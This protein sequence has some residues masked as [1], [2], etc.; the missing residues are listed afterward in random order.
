[1][2]TIQKFNYI[3]LEQTD[4]KL[5]HFLEALSDKQRKEI[6]PTIQNL[7][8]ENYKLQD[9][10]GREIRSQYPYP[11]FH[12]AIAEDEYSNSLKDI[13]AKLHLSAFVCKENYYDDPSA[14]VEKCAKTDVLSWYF[15]K[16][17]CTNVWL[18]EYYYVMQKCM[19]K[20]N[21]IFSPTQI[22][23]GIA[24]SG[25]DTILNIKPSLL[26]EHFWYLFQYETDVHYLNR[27]YY[28]TN[29]IETLKTL[30]KEK[31]ISKNKL[32]QHILYTPSM[33]HSISWTNFF[34]DLIIAL[35]PT[36]DELLCVQKELFSVLE[37]TYTKPINVI[38]KLIKQIHKAKKFDIESFIE[39]IPFLLASETKSIRNAT[40]TIIDSLFK[41]YSE[42]K[43]MLGSHLIQTFIH[44]D[45]SL[46]VKV[47]K[48]FVK[49]KLT[50]IPSIIDALSSYY[51]DLFQEAQS[52]LPTPNNIVINE[53]VALETTKRTPVNDENIM[54]QYQ[55]FD[56]LLFF[57]SQVF[58]GNNPYDFDLFIA[59]LPKL[60]LFLN[61]SNA[62]KVEPIFQ[63]ADK[64]L[65]R[66]INNMKSEISFTMAQAMLYYGA[67][68]LK[69][70]PQLHQKVSRYYLSFADEEK[71]AVE[72]YPWYTS[73]LIDFFDIPPSA[74]IFNIHR[75][76]IATMLR[77]IEKG[78]VTL[79]IFL[80][81]HTP[82]WIDGKALIDR[83][84]EQMNLAYQINPIEFQIAFSRAVFENT[85]QTDTLS[86]EIKK[87]FDYYCNDA[88]LKV[89]NIEEPALWI[90]PILRKNHTHD[91]EL[92]AKELQKEHH[93]ISFSDIFNGTITHRDSKNTTFTSHSVQLLR[94][95]NFYTI[96][97]HNR[98]RSNFTGE[99]IDQT[100]ILYLTPL[101]PNFML[102]TIYKTPSVKFEPFMPSL[103][104]I[105]NDFGDNAYLFIAR[106][107]TDENKV[108]RQFSSELWIKSVSEGTMNHKLL[109][110]TLGKLEHNE[111]TPLKRFTDLII[112]NMLNISSL[113]NQALHELLSYMIPN[114]NDEPIKGTKKLLEIYLE[115]LSLT[116][117]SVPYET[118]EKLTVWQE[119]KSLSSIIKKVKKISVT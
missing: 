93:D 113:H 105:W 37:Y 97:H 111:Y 91:L 2:D 57:F 104:E 33:G 53:P 6:E 40:V 114:M 82:C 55:S 17:I 29:W 41:L 110:E 75:D 89:E 115:I 31:K 83:V 67:T 69:H 65:K 5:S 42:Y 19:E 38:L 44:Q 92:F 13:N 80:P 90:A 70:I 10:R 96:F 7:M 54:P 86:G 118:L 51:E 47:A 14:I 34:F 95:L 43:E 24:R 66:S 112:S 27:S 99:F 4:E 36:T 109:G 45:N 61:A 100:T 117:L 35:T 48:I 15:P 23:E 73:R 59:L 84:S 28:C 16:W 8:K 72:Q 108:T 30:V 50:E 87:I 81:T 20:Y 18:P 25:E 46:Q 71:K 1:M 11:E 116:K 68:Y 119:T 60:H 94:T 39:K 52:I 98:L 76:L 101:L 77:E 103:F 26:D 107:L 85:C 106:T 79:S 64:H 32:L 88:S 9:K 63:Q 21:H 62:S 58:E 22:A 3:V 74:S 102:E 78:D 12:Q 49:H 56:E